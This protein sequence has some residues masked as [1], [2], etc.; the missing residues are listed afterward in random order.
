MGGATLAEVG[1]VLFKHKALAGRSH[2][3]SVGDLLGG[4]KPGGD[5]FERPVLRQHAADKAD[6]GRAVRNSFELA[7]GHFFIAAFNQ[8]ANTA[9][10]C[11]MQ[12]NT[13]QRA[14]MHET[15]FLYKFIH[16]VKGK[17]DEELRVLFHCLPLI[18]M[19]ASLMFITTMTQ[20]T[21]P[22]AEYKRVF[23]DDAHAKPEN[24][25]AGTAVDAL[26]LHT[27]RSKELVNRLQAT[28]ESSIGVVD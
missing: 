15:T 6:S 23:G 20:T 28:L 22:R 26:Y 27:D 14:A 7:I 1:G 3:I 19:T 24:A 10:A 13:T 11:T 25:L 2:G 4:G 16:A 5:R 12:H 17:D 21:N 9:F 18:M 8:G